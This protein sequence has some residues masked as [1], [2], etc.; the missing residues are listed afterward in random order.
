MR[1]QFLVRYGLGNH[2]GRNSRIRNSRKVC[3]VYRCLRRCI[4][5]RLLHGSGFGGSGYIRVRACIGACKK[6][7]GKCNAARRRGNAQRPCADLYML[8][9]F[10]H[11]QRRFHGLCALVSVLRLKLRAAGGNGVICFSPLAKARHQN[12][13]HRARGVYIRARVALV[14]AVLLGRRIAARA[15][16]LR[17]A[18]LAVLKQPCRTKIDKLQYAPV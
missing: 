17:V 15:N 12:V 14:K 1:Q 2:L 7:A 11:A 5:V 18:W 10:C 16:L 3:H 4:G 8:F 6:R 9:I 13:Q